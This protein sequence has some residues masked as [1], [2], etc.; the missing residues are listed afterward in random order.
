[1]LC[2]HLGNVLQRTDECVVAPPAAAVAPPP[3]EPAEGALVGA[4]PPP[5][6][7]FELLPLW[8]Y[9]I[10]LVAEDAWLNGYSAGTEALQA[11]SRAVTKRDFMKRMAGDTKSADAFPDGQV[12]ASAF[13]FPGK[14]Y[15]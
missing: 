12:E 4:F 14:S 13:A 5:A 8:F 1:M 6:R 15:A 7:E 9:V 2:C 10:E 11:F 3:N